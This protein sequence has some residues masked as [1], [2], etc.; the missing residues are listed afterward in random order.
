MMFAVQFIRSR[1]PVGVDEEDLDW[2][3][4]TESPYTT[5]S[6]ADDAARDYEASFD[7]HYAHRVVELRVHLPELA[8][9]EPRNDA[10]R[11][12]A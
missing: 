10:A 12:R 3:T 5:W 4:I 8:K 1:R 7:G 2:E 9:A 11:R 6:A